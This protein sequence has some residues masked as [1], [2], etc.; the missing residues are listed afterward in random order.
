MTEPTDTVL[1]ARGKLAVLADRIERLDTE[2][3]R[4][5]AAMIRDGIRDRDRATLH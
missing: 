2:R 5:L 1:I 3:A 4:R